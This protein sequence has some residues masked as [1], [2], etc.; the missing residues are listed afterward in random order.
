MDKSRAASTI[1]HYAFQRLK[2]DFDLV[3]NDDGSGE[4]A[5]LVGLK[6]VDEKTIRLCLIHCKNAYKGVIFVGHQ[7]FYVRCGQAQKSA[8]VKHHGMLRL[9]TTNSG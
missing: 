2:A 5:D 8:R 3:F 1:Q 9:Y 6:E 7:N 4:A